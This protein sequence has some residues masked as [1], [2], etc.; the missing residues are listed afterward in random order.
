MKNMSRKSS[1]ISVEITIKTNHDCDAFVEWFRSQDRHVEQ[2]PCDTHQWLVYFAPIPCPNAD[3]T[4][5]TLCRTI[6]ELPREV[7]RQWDEA[8]F[9]EFYA[10]Y[11]VGDEPFCYQEHLGAET[12]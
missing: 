7:R 4:I 5:Q 8:E 9:K 6:Q 11:E 1:F 10:G 3:A 12:I 2:L